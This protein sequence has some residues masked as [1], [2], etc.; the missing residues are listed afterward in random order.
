MHGT[1]LSL[2]HFDSLKQSLILHVHSSVLI[3]DC[4]YH[5]ALVL[6]IDNL[7]RICL[8]VGI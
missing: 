5:L 1:C 7:R 8:V 4:V 2:F 3:P 6:K